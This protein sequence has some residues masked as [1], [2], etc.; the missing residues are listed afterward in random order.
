M[1]K[2]KPNRYGS[3]LIPNVGSIR[4]EF[5]M[6]CAAGLRQNVLLIGEQ[7]A[8][9]DDDGGDD[10]RWHIFSSIQGSAKTTLVYSYLKKKNPEE[11]VITNSNFSSSTTPQIFQKSIE[12]LVDK[13]MGRYSLS[14]L[15]FSD[16]VC[17][18]YGPPPGKTMFTFIDDLNLP[19]I[20]AWG[21]QAS[22]CG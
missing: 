8:H 15:Y 2:S 10:G 20:N 1:F 9:D 6:A 13:R 17:S 22:F 12:A 3:L 16:H 21:D 5:L 19:E 14:L 18:V 11:S 4:T 7:V